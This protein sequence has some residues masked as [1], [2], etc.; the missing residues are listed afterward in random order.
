MVCYFCGR[1]I[2]YFFGEKSANDTYEDSFGDKLY[3]CLEC[4]KKGLNNSICN[5]CFSKVF[6]PYNEETSRYVIIPSLDKNELQIV[7]ICKCKKQ[8]T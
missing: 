7:K 8:L 2:M 1:K 3:I 4:E 5:R 6:L